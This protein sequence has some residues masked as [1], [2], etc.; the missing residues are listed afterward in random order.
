[1]TPKFLKQGSMRQILYQNVAQ[2]SLSLFLDFLEK[3]FPELN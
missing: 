2:K 1:M 3:R